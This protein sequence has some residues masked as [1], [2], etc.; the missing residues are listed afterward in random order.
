MQPL[1]LLQLDS[2]SATREQAQ[3]ERADV[4]RR[5]N[6]AYENGYQS[7][8][9]SL[10]ERHSKSSGESVIQ[11]DGNGKDGADTEAMKS[12]MATEAGEQKRTI[13]LMEEKVQEL[14][15]SWTVIQERALKQPSPA[16]RE[17]S[18]DKQLQTLIEQLAAKQGTSRG[19]CW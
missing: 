15:R 10:D 7:L 4:A 17:K 12:V 16:Q 19:D 14:E 11:P 2:H 5:E 13:W 9:A 3:N 6:S 1:T 8:E 18:L